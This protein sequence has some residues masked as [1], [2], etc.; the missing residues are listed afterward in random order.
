MTSSN[1]TPALVR[2]PVCG[3]TVSPET[4]RYSAQHSGKKYFF[5]CGSCADK[6]LSHPQGYVNRAAP[7]LVTLGAPT[8]PSGTAPAIE[9]DLVCGMNVNAVAAKHI[10]ERGGKK[11]Y[12]C[13]SGCLEKFK[14]NPQRYLSS[15][16]SGLVTSPSPFGSTAPITANSS[17]SGESESQN[18]YVCPMCP[19]VRETKPVPCPKC[20]MALEPESPSALTRTEYTCPMHPEIVRSGPG[21]CPICGM[22]LEPRTVTAASED[23]PELH[24]MTA[25]F[26]VGVALTAPLLAIS[27]GGMIWPHHVH[28]H[29]GRCA[30]S[31]A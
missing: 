29:A 18:S 1:P 31:M 3:M 15:P 7:G 17:R 19:G 9:R 26:W 20:G 6:F 10:H 16:P 30:P 2:D 22:A 27:M 21:S 12:F 4:A 28:A 13:S 8:V 24:D 14:S 23:N 25:R 11:Y 5:C